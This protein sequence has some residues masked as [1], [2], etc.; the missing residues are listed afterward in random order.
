M[1]VYS[2]PGLMAGDRVHLGQREEIILAQM[3]AGFTDRVLNKV[4]RVKGERGSSNPTYDKIWDNV[5]KLEGQ[6]TS[7]HT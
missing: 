7:R 4:E 2:A 6:G 5:T 3:L 1:V